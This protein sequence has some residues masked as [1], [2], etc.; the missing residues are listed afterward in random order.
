MPTAGA[1]RRRRTEDELKAIAPHV[2]YE[3]DVFY[4][5]AH[6]LDPD[7]PEDWKLRSLLIEGFALHARILFLFF[8]G[9]EK[10]RPDDVLAEDFM[11]SPE[12]WRRERPR[13]PKPLG[14]LS[15]RVAKE[16]AHLTYARAQV[17]KEEKGWDIRQI[18]E[19]MSLILARFGNR[20][21][22]GRR[23]WFARLGD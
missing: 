4:A 14:V 11:E 19:L 12:D 9:D 6:L 1:I 8:Y 2:Q 17:P 10:A 16:V 7:L 15:V 3:I 5:A 23:A 13:F 20:L 21:P 22:P 18:V